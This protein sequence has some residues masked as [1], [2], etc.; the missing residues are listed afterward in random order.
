MA[1][2]RT[3]L[4]SDA[5]IR[6]LALRPRIVFGFPVAKSAITTAVAV[7]G[8]TSLS[9]TPGFFK[10]T[11]IGGPFFGYCE[12]QVIDSDQKHRIDFFLLAFFFVLE[13]TNVLDSAAIDW[14]TLFSAFP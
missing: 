11:K 1:A 6:K 13:I 8:E 9:F 4:E 10:K 3:L 5:S 14:F 2:D 12:S 7:R